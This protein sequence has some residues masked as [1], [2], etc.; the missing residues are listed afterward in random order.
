MLAA[1]LRGRAPEPPPDWIYRLWMSGNEWNSQARVL[2]EVARSEEEGIPVGA[3]VIEAWSDEETLLP[4]PGLTDEPHVHGEP[5]TLSDFTFHP[6]G[7]WPY[8]KD[9]SPIYMP[10]GVKVLLCRSR[11]RR[12]ATPKHKLPTTSRRSLLAAT[13]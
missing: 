4:S 12:G 8:R 13:A 5:H 9:L 3:I 6:A 10:E 1:F 7:A 11:S 2:A